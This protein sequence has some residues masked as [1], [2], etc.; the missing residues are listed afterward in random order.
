[1]APKVNAA[2]E[3][4][5]EDTGKDLTKVKPSENKVAILRRISDPCHRSFGDFVAVQQL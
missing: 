3:E 5:L 2:N 4:R 1:M